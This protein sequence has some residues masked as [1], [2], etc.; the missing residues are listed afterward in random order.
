MTEPTPEDLIA[1]SGQPVSERS[2]Q[3]WWA[4]SKKEVESNL[5]NTNYENWETIEGDV[6]ETLDHKPPKGPIALLRL[7][8]DWYEST[9]KELT[10]L[11]PL[12]VKGGI[13]LLDDYG[14]FKGAAKAVDE[15][16][17]SLGI[18]P[19]LQRV[20]YTGRLYIKE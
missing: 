1:A 8:T 17:S 18:V 10:V 13:L 14:H 9:K 11:F 5:K 4:V 6:L 7:D 2:P 3:G 15:Y 16:F 20:D 19:L 12:L